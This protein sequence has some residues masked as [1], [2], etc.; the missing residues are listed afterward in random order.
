MRGV[1]NRGALPRSP[2]VAAL[3]M[4]LT[5]SAG[6]GTSAAHAAGG[7]LG[8]PDLPE[9]R[10]DQVR[11]PSGPGAR[12]ARAQVASTE[13]ANAA[14]ARRADTQQGADWPAAAAATARIPGQGAAKLSVGGLP[15][16]VAHGRGAAAAGQVQVRVLRQ[17]QARAAGIEGV[18][19]TASASQPGDAR[20]SVDYSTFA[21]AY[22]GDWSGRLRLFRLPACAL[23]TPQKAAC[24]TLTPLAS[25]ND[26]GRQTLTATVGLGS[27]DGGPDAVRASRSAPRTSLPT[28]DT[29]ASAT[30][31]AVTSGPSGESASGAG[32]YA[33]SPLSAS[34]GWQ[35]GGS[36]G[37][38]TWSYPLSAPPA[39]AGPAP[40]L[41]LSY[42]SGSVDGR[43]ASTNNQGG[44]VG[45][46]FGLTS[47]YVERSYGS[48]D[49]DGQDGKYD[50]CWKYDNASL[51]LNGKSTELVKDDTTGVWHLE[52]D[53]ASTV[54]HATGADN[55]DDDGEYWSVTTGDGTRYVF[56]LNKLPGAGTQRTNSAWTVPVF[57]DDAGEPGY[58]LGSSF[59]DRAVNQAWRWNLDY[60]VDPHG[61]AMSYWY[62]AET[63][64]YGKNG[65]ST[66]TTRYTRGGYLTK[67][68]YGQ[69]KDTLF[70]GTASDEVTFG[71]AERCTAS[72]CSSLTSS[73]ASDWPDVPFDSICASGADCRAANP[74]FFTRKRLT[75]IDTHAWSAASSSY[76]DVDS[77]ALTQQYLDPGDIGSSSDQTLVLKTIRHTG[78]NGTA[79]SLDPV[80]FTYQMR[81]NRVDSSTDN[82]LP[83]NRPRIASITSEAGAITT[84][85]LS[86]PECVRG[87][88]MPSAEDND[89]MSCYPVYWHVNGATEASLDWFNKY[90][91]L[92]VVTSDPTGLG[93]TME[94][95]Y[96]YSGPA[97]HHND[98]PLTPTKER[99]W[100]D[101]RGYRTVTAITG[102]SGETQS[103]KVSLYLQGMDGDK[104]KDGTTRSVTVPGTG[105]PGLSVPAQT[106]SDRYSGFTREQITYNGSTPVAVTVNDP[107]SAR[108]AA[109]HKSYAD[110][111]A[112]FVRTRT[113]RVSTYLT[114]GATWRTHS[115]TTG[116]DGYGMAAT[117]DDAGDT[118]VTGDET[119]TRT[120]YARN[121]ALGINSLVSRTRVVGRA[122]ST[123]ETDLNLP[124]SAGTRG[125]VLSD[126]AIVYDDASATAWKASRTPTLGEVTWTGR[127]SAYPATAT[128]GERY[129]TSWS[130][131]T[132]ATHDSL[133]RPLTATDA[134]GHT[135]T[136]AYTPAATG[137]LTKTTVT[138]PKGQKTYTYLDHARGTP[139]KVYD[140]NIKLTEST[141]DALGRVTAVWLPNR[142]RAAGYGP[143][144]TYAYSVSRK[145]APW[146]STSAIRG[147]G[148]YSTV[149]TI[150]DSLLRPLQIQ[151]PTADGGRR[152]TDTRY[153]SRGL[154][155]ETYADVFDS[156]AAPSGTYTRALSGGAP[157]QTDIVFDGAGRQTSSTFYVYGTKKWTTSTSY[158]GD[159][160]ATT[161][162]SGGSAVRTITDVFGRTT[163]RREY[164]GENPADTAYGAGVGAAYTS[165]TFT[166]TRDGKADTVTGPDGTRWSYGYDLFGRQVKATDPDKGTTTTSYTDLDQPAT[167]TD[168][169]NTTL[170]YGYDELGRKTDEWQTS[171]TDD[172]KLAH[173]AYDSL[174]KGHLDS[175]T[176]Y[177]GGVSGAA[178]TRKVTA[179][180]SL[181]RP[182]T[183]QLVLPSTD[184][185]VTSGAV[186]ATLTSSTHYNLDGNRQY[187]SEPAAGGLAAETVNTD[188]NSV[189]LPT[190]VSGTSD[191]LLGAAYSATGQVEQLILGTS[192]AEGTK[193]A[194]ITNT[195]EEGT[196]RLLQAAVTDQTHGYELQELNYTY[197]D[198]GNV[199]SLTDPTTLGGTG[200]SDNQCFAYDGHR[201]LTD[202]WTPGTDDCSTAGRATANLAGASP[203][204]TS[205]T[206]TGSGLRTT[207]TDHTSAGD[208]T[209]TYCYD[210]ARPHALTATTTASSCTG[211]TP[212]H[213]YDPA[214]N[215]TGRPNGT[216]T[217]ALT[218]N[219]EGRLDTL[220]EKTGTGT[221]K[222]T[223]SHLYDAD[224]TL[225]IRRNTSAQTVLYLDGGT[226]VH[227]DTSTSTPKYW[228]QRYYTA[229][230]F[231]IALRTDKAGTDTLT[232]LAGDQHGTRS[233]A[234]DSATQ[235]VTKRY[236]SPF[237]APRTG[238]TGSWPDDRAFLGAPADTVTGLTH[239]GAREYDPGTG[240]FL[241]VDPVLDVGDAQSLNGYTYADD[242][243]TT[244]SDPTG[245]RD[246]GETEYCGKGSRPNLEYG[247]AAS[248]DAKIILPSGVHVSVAS[249]TGNTSKTK[250]TH[251]KS[252][253]WRSWLSN[254]KST[255]VDY[256]SAIFSQPEIWWGSA[257]T[258]GSMV[259]MGLGADTTI[260]G[261]AMCLTGVGCIAG[262]PVAL[263]GVAMVGTGAYGV[264][265]GIGRINDGLGKA[266]SEVN[267]ESSGSAGS[268]TFT[269]D[270][271]LV[272]DV[273]TAIDAE[274]PGLVEDVNVP[275]TRPDG[276]TLTDFDIELKNA[277]IQVKAGPG[278]GAGAQVTR[279]QEG[280]DKPVIVYGPKLRPSVVK[281][282]NSRGGVGVTS[283]DDLLAVVAP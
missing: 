108:T 245:L 198:A 236:S 263:G 106:D 192:A 25:R 62:T 204:W 271:P 60:V 219:A 175:S 103:K 8:R 201:R 239:L 229:G 212:T 196:D 249:N 137:P 252:G 68:L 129:P 154:V 7:G 121:T 224:G 14:Q 158:T 29:A 85:T 148:V 117:V 234:L 99:T 177:A 157:K 84:V 203:Y 152:L 72:D 169:R 52:D 246:C 127:A 49:D 227:L 100:S 250:T 74:S 98:D 118:S 247:T 269:S 59:A 76:T 171:K 260:A 63:N 43:T 232:W 266:L 160:A 141:Y 173:W 255:V 86:D 223:I 176:S 128:N 95:H 215:T 135:T 191:Y 113:T 75:G 147:E 37:A 278:K 64:Y 28:A 259:L 136:T 134:A 281:E 97:W 240:R 3:C 33:A 165:T 50:L 155:H 216:D 11:T 202:A 94:S 238:G 81:E 123:A 264:S 225:L 211:V 258:A 87:S 253:G 19:L 30:V 18:L 4:A 109:Q 205:Y 70:T 57:G 276:S 244:G 38:F 170:L 89:T 73:T 65:A 163:E 2:V 53:D 172:R 207:E 262:A 277:V 183:T 9:Q 159:S 213:T 79:I 110:I 61:N 112:Y 241:S 88:R 26:V 181:Y 184:P 114:V 91:V 226:E 164:A 111:D 23:A 142:S 270:D 122:C 131:V 47:S 55:G 119:C 54:T 185:L 217:Q 105:F 16:T 243:P 125:D 151:S 208:T 161:S 187:V 93:E 220:V 13:A 222:S 233:I 78:R 48:C 231:T 251:K 167:T 41:S 116:F 31:L 153:D 51:V 256:G 267:S 254:A 273:A 107:W 69:N 206:H 199:T 67:I 115:T 15:V 71:Y 58:D 162:L 104:Q 257:E 261:G 133:G 210:A 6:V 144:Y 40:Q 279:T 124:A 126:T 178:Y 190:G 34:S 1:L 180:D 265:D 96:S 186:T 17:R 140:A 150:Y 179:Y 83:L 145:A 149:Y 102:A 22:G 221:P 280:T 189:G 56:G 200:K 228:A 132:K 182:T 272:G 139:V 101:W 20:V 45:E 274:Y 194:Y 12:K 237:G 5:V 248:S 82:I 80:T 130:T 218:W 268:R 90:R 197:D 242:N 35:A 36:S 214:G 39:A 166:Y 27:A 188:Y 156:T 209:T 10:V 143:N 168:S 92:D 120:W 235:A 230:G 44:V 282:V 146:S 275:A 193:K 21:A 77:W 283:M 24:R 32:S 138:N 46:G 174:A 42:D 195:W 66:G